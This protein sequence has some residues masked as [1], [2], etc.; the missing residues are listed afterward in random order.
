MNYKLQQE[1]KEHHLQKHGQKHGC[2][3]NYSNQ[4]IWNDPLWNLSVSIWAVSHTEQRTSCICRECWDSRCLTSTRQIPTYIWTWIHAAVLSAERCASPRQKR[5]HSRSVC[6]LRDGAGLQRAS[7][8]PSCCITVALTHQL[9]VPL[10]AQ[11][12]WWL[13]PVRAWQWSEISL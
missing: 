13:R 1:R 5:C 7:S 12:V 8:E 11:H 9:L 4:T 10:T 6:T 3:S 2:H